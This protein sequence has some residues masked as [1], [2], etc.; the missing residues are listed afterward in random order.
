MTCPRVLFFVVTMLGGLLADGARARPQRTVA[1]T[2]AYGPV[3]GARIQ[4]VGF[5]SGDPSTDGVGFYIDSARLSVEGV[6]E[7]GVGYEV[8]GDFSEREVLKDA[9]LI[10]RATPALTLRGGQFKAPFSYGELLSSSK[11]P[12]V[13][14]PRVV[15]A[16]NVGRN[17]GVEA[18]VTSPSG[19]WA[20]RGGIF[21]EAIATE[22]DG[23]LL[24]VGR[25]TWRPVIG[26]AEAVIGVNAAY[27]DGAG[28]FREG[29]RSG[30]DV[31]VERG[32]Y[33]A[34]AEVL[35]AAERPEAGVSSGAYTTVGW[36]PAPAHLL[37]ARWDYVETTAS[38]VPPHMLGLGYTFLPSDVIRIEADLIVPVSPFEA[39][40]A[41]VLVNLQLDF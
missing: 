39:Q 14:R 34:T 40:H 26:Q 3:L 16:L 21:D 25:V 27:D 38:A 31:R 37:R 30:A 1:D 24:Y 36:A 17:V 23:R 28:G 6:V 32:P 8:E 7:G 10:Y 15:D 20:V 12:F 22:A 41:G 11:T 19:A 29:L 5:L 13:E 4:T 9:L 35:A 2:T 18:E 33:F